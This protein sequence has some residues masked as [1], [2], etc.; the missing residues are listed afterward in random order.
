MPIN[1]EYAFVV[2]INS[3]YLKSS[4]NNF[5]QSG[6]K[7]SLICRQ[8]CYKRKFMCLTCAHLMLKKNNVIEAGPFTAKLV[9]LTIQVYI[10]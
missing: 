9:I 10:S 3:T 4:Y 6:K 7:K 2:R 8:L 1:K 5:L